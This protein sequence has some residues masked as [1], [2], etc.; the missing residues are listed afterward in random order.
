[1]DGWD[2]FAVGGDPRAIAAQI[3]EE[4]TAF[5]LLGI[6]QRPLRQLDAE[7]RES[8]CKSR[9]LLTLET[10]ME[11]CRRNRCLESRRHASV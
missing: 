10:R 11:S 4:C 2:Q 3:I 9:W 8:P 6:G 1:M 5:D 7:Y